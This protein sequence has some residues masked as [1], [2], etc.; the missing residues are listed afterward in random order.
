M[1][2]RLAKIKVWEENGRGWSCRKWRK[3]ESALTKVERLFI[4]TGDK[5]EKELSKK[6]S[7]LLP[8]TAKVC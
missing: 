3:T 2:V 6:M 8:K 4:M 1:A 7:K 5:R